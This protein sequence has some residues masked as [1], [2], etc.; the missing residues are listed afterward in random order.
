ML[1]FLKFEKVSAS[2]QK[3]SLSAY[4]YI[5]LPVKTK[6]LYNNFKNIFIEIEKQ[7]LSVS[8]E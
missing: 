8:G 7:T 2:H 4:T 5:L 1:I 3:I 6:E